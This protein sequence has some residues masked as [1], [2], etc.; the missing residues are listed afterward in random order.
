MERRT[1]F[2]KD[3]LN[4][5]FSGV[6]RNT[7]DV[8]EHYVYNHKN[9]FW[10]ITEFFVY[11]IVM[12]PVAY[13]YLKIK[14]HAKFVN[15]SVLNENKKQPIFLFGNHTMLPGDGYIP[16]AI[17]FPKKCN[18]IVN[19]DNVSLNGTKTFMKMVGAIPI[20]NKI[21]GMRNY[22]NFLESCLNKKRCVAIYPEAHVW[23]YYTK[24]RPFTYSSFKYPVIYNTPV[25][26]FTTTYQ[27]KNK[28]ENPKITVYVD[29][30]FYADKNLLKKEA[31]Q[32]LRDVVYEKMAERSKCSTYEYNVFKKSGE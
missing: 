20:P 19:A 21:S 8:D 28:S 18:E 10:K 25:Y 27:K 26:C 6:V 31:A 4:D 1:Y 30:P 32:K 14:Y 17:M 13:L 3:E 29:G 16:T 23:P 5:E 15:K 22:T 24:I 7:I 9:I 2:Y 12:T 11:R